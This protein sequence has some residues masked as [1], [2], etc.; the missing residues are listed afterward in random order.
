LAVGV[1]LAREQEI[2][3]SMLLRLM[4]PSGYW[5][6]VVTVLSCETAEMLE[7]GGTIQKKQSCDVSLTLLFLPTRWM[8][9]TT[10]MQTRSSRL[11]RCGARKKH[12]MTPSPSNIE[13]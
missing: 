11:T 5:S 12:L 9:W 6:E 10:E 1:V 2:E 8:M 4:M 13:C 7:A 3:G